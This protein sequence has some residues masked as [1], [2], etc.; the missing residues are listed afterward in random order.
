MI[1]LL[2][3]RSFGAF[4]ASMFLGAFNDNAFKVLVLFLVAS[5]AKGEGLQVADGFSP[6]S[7]AE[8][9]ADAVCPA[10]RSCSGP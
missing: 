10:V 8:A 2:K 1:G 4:T 7:L 3:Q 6:K 5:L 9:A